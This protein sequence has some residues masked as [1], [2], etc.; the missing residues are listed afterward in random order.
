[1]DMTKFFQKYFDGGALSKHWAYEEMNWIVR[2]MH[3][4]KYSCAVKMMLELSEFSY[5]NGDERLGFRLLKT[6][7]IINKTIID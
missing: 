7:N 5:Q 2:L 3:E 6:V 4:K 1:M